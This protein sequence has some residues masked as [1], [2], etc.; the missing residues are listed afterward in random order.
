VSKGMK[1]YNRSRLRLELCTRVA[2]KMAARATNAI[3]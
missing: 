3:E 2:S 1:I